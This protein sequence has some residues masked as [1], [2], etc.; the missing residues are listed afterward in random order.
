MRSLHLLFI[1]F[2]V[3]CSAACAA[4][5]GL[6]SDE[7]LGQMEVGI[8]HRR[9]VREWFGTPDRTQADEEGAVF[10]SYRRTQPA[11]TQRLADFAGHL[12]V[13]FPPGLPNPPAEGIHELLEVEFSPTGAVRA[14][15]HERSR[16]SAALQP[17][18]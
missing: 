18:H 10:W 2:G 9:Q 16:G 17:V 8:T 15:S 11:A 1:A 7:S 12:I 6:L 4:T 14:F 3:A 13:F 5:N